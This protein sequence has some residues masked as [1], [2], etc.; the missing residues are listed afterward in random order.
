MTREQQ[1]RQLQPHP[2]AQ[3]A[4]LADEAQGLPVVPLLAGV[5]ETQ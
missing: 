5:E 1:L 4:R 2:G 3:R